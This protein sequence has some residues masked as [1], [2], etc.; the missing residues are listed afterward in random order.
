MR[1]SISLRAG[2]IAPT[3]VL[4]LSAQ[5]VLIDKEVAMVVDRA[6]IIKPE[7]FTPERVERLC[8]EFLHTFG[9]DRGLRRLIIGTDEDTVSLALIH[10][11]PPVVVIED[12]GGPANSRAWDDRQS[13]FNRT[14]ETIR[15]RSLPRSPIARVL[16]VG[17][18]AMLTVRDTRGYREKLLAGT[19]DPTLVRDG[20]ISYRLLHF[21][22]TPPGPALRRDDYV[23][24]IYFEAKPELSV[25]SVARLT[26]RFKNIARGGQ[27]NVAVRP[28]TFFAEYRQYPAV[29]PFLRNPI[30]P[31]SFQYLVRGTL[32]C[33][34]VGDRP[35]ACSGSNF[36]P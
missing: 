28:D 10:G 36:H 19:S 9:Q 21:V 16:A 20:R 2:F 17:D 22:L 26:L 6:V 34:V 11:S 27:L 4:G 5:T 13:A 18:A 30:V 33:G 3:I 31:S 29:L 23:T 25:S 35:I 14:V 15:N 8:R 32:T 7:E 24:L 12:S 1:W